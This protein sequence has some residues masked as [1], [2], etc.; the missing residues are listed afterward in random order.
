MLVLYHKY[1][2]VNKIC[3]F[4]AEMFCISNRFKEG[5]ETSEQELLFSDDFFCTHSEEWI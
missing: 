1:N 4:R 2:A 3:D 5:K